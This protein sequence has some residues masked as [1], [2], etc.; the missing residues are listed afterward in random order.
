MIR[1]LCP[2]GFSKMQ[3]SMPQPAAPLPNNPLDLRQVYYTVR[4]RVWIIACSLVL[5]GLASTTYLMRTPKI[6]AAKGVQQEDLQTLEFLKTVEQTL[7][8]RTLLERVIDTNHLL[9]DPRLV[10][11]TMQ[12][13]S[14]QQL[15]ARLQKMVEVR[16]RKGTRLIDI[17]VEHTEPT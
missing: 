15:V 2:K 5:A 3:S 16:L 1:S 17:K 4:E 13:P 7:Q 9:E 8:S 10:L 11:V 14:K 12:K 6:Y